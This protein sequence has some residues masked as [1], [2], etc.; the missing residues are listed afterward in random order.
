MAVT[1]DT[2]IADLGL[3]TQAPKNLDAEG[4]TTVGQ[5]LTYRRFAI[6]EIRGMGESRM[7]DLDR[8]LQLSGL[9]YGQPLVVHGTYLTCTACPACT[10]CGMPRATEAKHVVVDWR[11]R[12]KHSTAPGDPCDGCDAYHRELVATAAAALAA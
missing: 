4:I 1:A 11:G 6:A 3:T 12:A 9:W 10:D 2:P 5:L 7:A 8:A